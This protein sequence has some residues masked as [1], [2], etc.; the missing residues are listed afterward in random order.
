MGNH[1][2]EGNDTGVS[3]VELLSNESYGEVHKV[4]LPSFG[5]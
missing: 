2:A 3:H 1:W 5:S 4:N